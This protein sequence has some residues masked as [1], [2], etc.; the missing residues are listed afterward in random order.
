[1]ML[2][3]NQILWTLVALWIV[4]G[5]GIPA[6]TSAASNAAGSGQ[7]YALNDGALSD[8]SCKRGAKQEICDWVK[9]EHKTSVAH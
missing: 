2:E 8:R 6:A 5:A 4:T 9:R 3:R 1:M 7:A